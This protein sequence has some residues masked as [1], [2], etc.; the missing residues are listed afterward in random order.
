MKYLHNRHR[1]IKHFPVLPF[2]TVALI[3]IILLD[4]WVELYHRISFPLYGIKYVRRRDYIKIDRH[5]LSYLHPFQKLNCI[6][7][8]Y[9]NGALKYISEVVGE[10]EKYWCG[11]KHEAKEGF[12]SPSYHDE[13]LEYGDAETFKK[14]YT[15]EK[16]SM[17]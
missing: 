2:I 4:F 5:K 14:V 11:I 7:C 1:F 12:N 9:V 6:Y 15:S 13:F 16:T 17:L 10:T 3:F 8:G